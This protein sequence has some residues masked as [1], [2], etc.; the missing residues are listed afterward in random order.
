MPQN[1]EVAARSPPLAAG[2]TDASN[3][4][5]CV[6][7]IDM[8]RKPMCPA[9]TGPPHTAVRLRRSRGAA[10]QDDT[11]PGVP[12]RCASPVGEV[13]VPAVTGLR[14]RYGPVEPTG[15]CGP[16]ENVASRTPLACSHRRV[17]RLS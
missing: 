10:G 2:R 16:P 8:V 12:M 15:R 13:T 9:R 3:G 11:T 14:L 6:G 5:A 7:F 1:C 17:T 4:P